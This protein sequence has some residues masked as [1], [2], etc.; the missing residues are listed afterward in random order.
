MTCTPVFAGVATNRGGNV[1]SRVW[2]GRVALG[3]VIRTQ[4]RA[5]S[6]AMQC[7]RHIAAR[8]GHRRRVGPAEDELVCT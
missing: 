6:G 5:R 2:L 8:V 4:G 7:G 1:R 3:Y